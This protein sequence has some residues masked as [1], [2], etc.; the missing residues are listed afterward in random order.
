MSIRAILGRHVPRKFKTKEEIDRIAELNAKGYSPSV[1]SAMLGISERAVKDKLS[2]INKGQTNEWTD[3]ERETLIRLYQNGI[4]KPSSFKPFLEH[5]A[6]WMIRNK[7]KKLVKKGVLKPDQTPAQ[8]SLPKTDIP[9]YQDNS[10]SLMERAELETE[11]NFLDL[12]S[13]DD[14]SLN[15]F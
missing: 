13:F 1:I 3:D 8:Y 12:S 10:L 6:D 14:D 9:S 5:K 7:I 4:R 11:L 15:I 2:E